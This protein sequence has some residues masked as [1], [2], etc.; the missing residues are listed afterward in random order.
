MLYKSVSISEK[1]AKVLGKE[2]EINYKVVPFK[3]W[4]YSLNV[5]LE[6]G[7]KFGI[8]TNITNDSYEMTAKIAI[9]HLLEDPRYYY[10][11]KKM[12]ASRDKY[13]E[14]KGTPKPSIFISPKKYSKTKI[15]S[16]K[17]IH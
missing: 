3:E 14:A 1:D 10:Y 2:F 5:E 7:S 8:L 11:L 9:A 15:T 16:K 4:H 12:E 6:H 13:W 17:I